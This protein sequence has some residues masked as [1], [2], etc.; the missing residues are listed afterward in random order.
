M[1]HTNNS[2]THMYILTYTHPYIAPPTTTTPLLLLVT[3]DDTDKEPSPEEDCDVI[4]GTEDA[5]ATLL[6]DDEEDEE[7]AED[8]R[9]DMEDEEE[10]EDEWFLVVFL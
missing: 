1:I 5:E 4:T 8:D 6:L 2:Y 9:D 7:D 3:S 10:E